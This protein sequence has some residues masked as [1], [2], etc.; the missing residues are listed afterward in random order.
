MRVSV[1][2]PVYNEEKYLD[3]C[4]KNLLNQEIKADE[5]IIVDND[6]TDRSLQIAK[7]YPVRIINEKKRGVVFVRNSGF[8]Q[9]QFEIIARCDADTIV[10]SNWIKVIKNHFKN[11]KIDAVGFLTIFYDHWLLKNNVFFPDLY[12]QV[13]KHLLGHETLA[14][15]GL[16]LTKKIW[17][18]I[19]N[20]ICLNEKTVHE[21]IDLSI[22]IAKYG[23]I[24]LDKKNPVY[25]SSRRI[26]NNPLSFFVEYPLRL[27]KTLAYHKKN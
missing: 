16:A 27:A 23:E 2:I 6:S 12:F 25:T 13:M 11:K 10:P 24:Y 14:G 17:M 15:P 9:S 4:L 26:K 21:D 1:V 5:I 3:Q 7:K 19:K 18:K 22:H 20:E 8:N